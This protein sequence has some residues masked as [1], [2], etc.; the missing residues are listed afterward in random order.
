MTITVPS[1][2]AVI[3]RLRLRK[4][5]MEDPFKEFEQTF[6]QR[7]RGDDFYD[8]L[9]KEIDSEDA[10]LVQRQALAGMMGQAILFR[11]KIG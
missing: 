11:C 9:Q 10:K 4:D 1:E 5:V 8:E 3:I 7:K 2:D 6:D